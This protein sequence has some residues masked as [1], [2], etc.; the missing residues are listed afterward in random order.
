MKMIYSSSIALRSYV[1]E[2]SSVLLC[3]NQ[4]SAL[5]ALIAE[6][7]DVELARVALFRPVERAVS[8]E[9]GR[10]FPHTKR[11]LVQLADA[12]TSESCRLFFW[13]HELS[14]TIKPLE[15]KAAA[16]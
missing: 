9:F 13:Q 8:E 14:V 2:Q 12:E 7:A 5:R 6:H 11:K 15:E 16:A 4:M 3:V 1:I 10:H